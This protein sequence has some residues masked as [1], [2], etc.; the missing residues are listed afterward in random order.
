MANK[1]MT[2]VFC[3]RHLPISVRPIRNHEPKAPEIL[4]PHRAE[5]KLAIDDLEPVIVQTRAVV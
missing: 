3:S 2:P 4:L 5:R 1:V